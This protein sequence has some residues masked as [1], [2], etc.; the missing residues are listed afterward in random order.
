MVA[1]GAVRGIT[2]PGRKPRPNQWP[3]L[4]RQPRC[5][6]VGRLPSQGR[7]AA[8]SLRK[9]RVFQLQHVSQQLCRSLRVRLQTSLLPRCR[10]RRFRRVHHLRRL[11][12]FSVQR[13]LVQ[14]RRLPSAVLFARFL[15]TQTQS[16]P[17][18][19]HRLLAVTPQT[20]QT[21]VIS[22]RRIPRTRCVQ[23]VERERASSR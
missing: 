17:A 8:T 5:W 20:L 6:H 11:Q 23:A 10:S 9:L 14:P 16:R 21:L 19:A 18:T 7:R 12:L 15:A 4:R 2:S 13:Q 1:S 3:P 22:C